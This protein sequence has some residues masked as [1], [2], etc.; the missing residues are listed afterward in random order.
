MFPELDQHLFWYLA[1]PVLWAF[2]QVIIKNER[3]PREPWNFEPMRT[4][5]QKHS[6]SDK[7]VM[8]CPNCELLFLKKTQITENKR[9]IKR[10]SLHLRS[11][12][13]K[14]LRELPD[15]GQF[16][17]TIPDTVDGQIVLEVALGKRPEPGLCDHG[18][19]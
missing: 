7:V 12:L 6:Q 3:L 16:G 15:G 4:R 19:I 13:G 18:E 14:E 10:G 2:H 9:S 5:V 1:R 17:H 11:H 8:L